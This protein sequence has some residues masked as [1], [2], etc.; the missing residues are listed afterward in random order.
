MSTQIAFVPLSP[1]I[2]RERQPARALT[3]LNPRRRWPNLSKPWR[4]RLWAARPTMGER[5]RRRPGRQEGES[6]KG[7]TPH[8]SEAIVDRIAHLGVARDLGSFSLES[9]PARA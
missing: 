1:A 8:R 9:S 3:G 5:D 2:T 7:K 4:I 6:E